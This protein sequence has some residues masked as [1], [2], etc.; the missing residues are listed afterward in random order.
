MPNSTIVQHPETGKPVREVV[1]YEDLDLIQ[2]QQDVLDKEAALNKLIADKK[3]AFEASLEED[4]DVQAA[5]RA[6]S[7]CKSEL[8][9]FKDIEGQRSDDTGEEESGSE[10]AADVEAGPGSSD[11][12][13]SSADSVE[14]TGADASTPSVADEN[15]LDLR[16]SSQVETA[17]NY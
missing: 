4:A 10:V 7:E 1:S 13:E 11:V 2:L 15:V 17:D 9:V 8:D 12:I 16:D 6:V 3:D 5:R 14:D